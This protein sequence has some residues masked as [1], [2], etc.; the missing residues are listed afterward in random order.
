MRLIEGSGQERAKPSRPC[1]MA[2]SRPSSARTGV[3]RTGSELTDRRFFTLSPVTARRSWLHTWALFGAALLAVH[4]G[5]YLLG[6][7]RH[8]QEAL[9]HQGH[10]YLSFVAPLVAISAAGVL[11][12][13]LVRALG[14]GGR[15]P[16]PSRS[17]STS[18]I[19]ISAGV[20]VLMLYVGQ[21][22]LEGM[23]SSGHPTGLAGIFGAGGWT[24]VPLS[25]FAGTVIALAV[26]I[27]RD[28]PR[29][30]VVLVTRLP[31]RA[32]LVSRKRSREPSGQR[33]APLAMIGAQRA[34]PLSV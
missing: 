33:C 29:L 26:G 19:A 31:S 12:L 7:G 32:P 14:A 15:S 21:E 34:P 8:A 13:L 16:S 9:A 1:P 2:P 17:W 24:A 6:Y 23:L 4:E 27:V 3:R 5:R 30:G 22:T 25:A 20:A 18:R 28:E 10:A 11:A